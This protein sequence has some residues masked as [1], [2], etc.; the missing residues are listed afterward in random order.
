[1]V[2]GKRPPSSVF[3]QLLRRN[4]V[5]MPEWRNRHDCPPSPCRNGGTATTSHLRHA[6][7]EEPPQPP[8]SAIPNAH[9][10]DLSLPSSVN[11]YAGMEEPPPPPTSAA[12]LTTTS[13]TSSLMLARIPC[14]AASPPGTSPGSLSAPSSAPE[15]S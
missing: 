10:N 9:V 2:R 12:P 7:M 1:M 11:C 5:A 3:T 13:S 4:G 8:T 14:A 6:R 15:S